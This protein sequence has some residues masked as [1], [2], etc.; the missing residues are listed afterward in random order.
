[1][2]T[3]QAVAPVTTQPARELGLDGYTCE[4]VQCTPVLPDGGGAVPQKY[5]IQLGLSDTHQAHLEVGERVPVLGSASVR[6]VLKYPEL[7]RLTAATVAQQLAGISCA[8]SS[9]CATHHL[10][11][12]AAIAPKFVCPVDAACA[13]ASAS[14]RSARWHTKQRS[15][16]PL[17]S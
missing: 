9:L 10:H 2:R 17:A 11:S 4:P 7:N 8:S 6:V 15:E 1:M 5:L 14:P 3:I 12:A 13:L 16:P